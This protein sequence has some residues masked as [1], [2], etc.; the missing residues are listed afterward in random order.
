MVMLY[1]DSKPHSLLVCNIHMTWR[2]LVNSSNDQ[3]CNNLPVLAV[4]TIA[5]LSSIETLALSG[6]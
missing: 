5:I 1:L 3:F 6:N 2:V 4:T